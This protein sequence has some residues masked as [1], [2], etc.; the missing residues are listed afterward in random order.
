VAPA[1]AATVVAVDAVGSVVLVPVAPVV[2]ELVLGAVF[3]DSMVVTGEAAVV[4]EE[5]PAEHPAK[6]HTRNTQA[7]TRTPVA[8]VVG[9][10]VQERLR[11]CS[12]TRVPLHLHLIARN[13]PGLNF[14]MKN[15]SATLT[16]SCRLAAA[17]HEPSSPRDTILPAYR[18]KN[19]LTRIG[20]MI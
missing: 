7:A 5:S 16:L 6:V 13:L 18:Q 1:A 2:V 10:S 19:M 3:D 20:V 8:H 9:T 12:R 17:A 15:T 14:Y 4:M 11:S